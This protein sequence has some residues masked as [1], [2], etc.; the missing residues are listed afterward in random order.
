[1]T[2]E[3]FIAERGQALLRLAYVLTSDSFLAQDIAQE[4]LAKTYRQWE[5]V[6]KSKNPEAYVNRILINGYIDSTRRKSATET[7]IQSVPETS[8]VSPDLAGEVANR[9]HIREV[10]AALPPQARTVLVMRY[11]ADLDDASIADLLGVTTSNVRATA[12]RALT[13]LRDSKTLGVVEENSND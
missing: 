11:Y 1:M 9:L 5:K 6:R 2:F 3:E 10:L 12:S 13:S 4:A 8:A 7:P